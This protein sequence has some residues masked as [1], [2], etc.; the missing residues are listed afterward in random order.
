[1]STIAKIAFRQTGSDRVDP[2]LVV[3][4]VGLLVLA[5]V[6]IAPALFIVS[7]SLKSTPDVMN[8]GAFTPPKSLFLENFPAAW[9]K[10]RFNVTFVNSLVITLVKVPL[11][12]AL[13]AM[14]AYALARVE[15]PAKKLLLGLVIFGTM[16]P[17]QVMLA[18]LFTIVN[19]MGL[20]N[21][22]V[23]VWLP[24]IAFGV[25]YQVFILH[26]FFKEVPQELSEAAVIDGASHFTIFRRIFL[27]ISL[28]VLAALLILDFVSTWN[29]FAMALVLLL[30]GRNWTLPL[31]LMAFQGEFGSDY[32]PLNAAIVTTVAPAVVVYLIFQRYFVG[33]LTAGAV[34][35]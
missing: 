1:V 27:P 17:F 22:Y 18:P 9:E 3:L 8:T 29:E 32:G 2:V 7:T 28:P 6:W 15:L 13:S 11:G 5:A 21:T 4:W 19:G 26:G 31:S 23:G 34:K 30:D 20:I 14:A 10:G 24:Y 35:G 33:G 16:I 25:P 12:L